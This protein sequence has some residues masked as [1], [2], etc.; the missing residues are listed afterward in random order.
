MAAVIAG[1]LAIVTYVWVRDY[2]L[3][4]RDEAALREAG[5][6]A[7]TVRDIVRTTPTPIDEVLRGLRSEPGSVILI[8]SGEAWFSSSIGTGPDS[9]PDSLLV[10]LDEGDAS[11]MRFEASGAPR[12]AVAVP[13]P[14]ADLAYVEIFPLRGID[15]TLSRLSLILGVGALLVAAAGAGVGTWA[16][17]RALRPL[18]ATSLAAALLAE[19]H[20]DARLPPDPDPDLDRL[21]G[22]F[23]EM[24][25]ALSE[26]IA[27]EAR[28]VSDVSHELRTP[29]AAMRAAADVLLRRR[30]E[31]TGRGREALDLLSEE[32]DEFDHLVSDLLEISRMDAGVEQTV[33]E[34]VILPD[35]F[36]RLGRQHGASDIEVEVGPNVPPDEVWLDKRRLER[37]VSNLLRN[38]AV[39]AG[40]AIRI[41][42]SGTPPLLRVEVDDAGPGVP[43][44]E[45]ER[46]FERFARSDDARQRPGS[47][48]GL[49]IAAEHARLLGGSVDVED[50]PGGGARFVVTFRVAR[51]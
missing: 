10:A 38:A 26:R 50:R 40:G 33:T 14:T 47:G 23:N 12:L 1:A 46:I 35:L 30:D 36:A 25:E 27:R 45:R 51:A 21:V 43:P 34:A 20:L 2:L 4:Q 24:A 29:V 48:L 39:H 17:R 37:V 8:R 42:V 44:E 31:L 18:S 6:N 49:A 5:A 41:G 13:I 16:T 19:G 9:L 15:N 28:F 3:D 11:R 32:V 22:A 7:R